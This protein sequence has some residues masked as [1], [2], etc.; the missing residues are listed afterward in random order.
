MKF[1]E[2]NIKDRELMPKWREAFSQSSF[3][4]QLGLAFFLA[5]FAMYVSVHWLSYNETRISEAF[6]D[7]ILALFDP[8][9]LSWPIS[10]ITNLGWIIGLL[11][12]ALIPFYFV[13]ALLSI[14]IISVFRISTMFLFPLEPPVNIIPLRDVLLENI[15]Y[16]DQVF[17][18]DLFFSG[19]TA[20]LILFCMLTPYKRIRVILAI[21]AV[22]V[23]TMLILQH[24][25]YTIDVIMAPF[26]TFIAFITCD[27]IAQKYCSNLLVSESK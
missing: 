20:V 12:A 4:F 3:K 8:V 11:S 16:Q 7:P 9:D 2:F 25:H 5:I 19:H 14:A 23:G 15:F 6:D 10:I 27:K 1:V 17:L 18:K 13:R 22:A 26:I 21:A 24:V